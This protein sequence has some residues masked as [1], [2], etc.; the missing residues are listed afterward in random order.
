MGYICQ[1]HLHIQ[2]LVLAQW[3]LLLIHWQQSVCT[4]TKTWGFLGTEYEQG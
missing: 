4:F 2:Y 3:E 1:Q